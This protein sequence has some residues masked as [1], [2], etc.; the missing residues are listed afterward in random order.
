M[1]SPRG[2]L[3]GLFVLALLAGSAHAQ[4][5]PTFLQ[6]LQA[7]LAS[8]PVIQGR[9][10]AE[11]AARSDL[12]G[13]NWQ[14]YP[15]PS[16]EVASQTSGGNT[17]LLRVEQPLWTGGRITAL[18][19]GAGRRLDA[20]GAAVDEISLDIALRVS[21]AYAEGLRQQGRL[22]HAVASVH[23][24]EKLLG[25]IRRR[26][27]QEVSPLVDQRLAEARLY[28]ASNDVSLATQA[29]DAAYAQLSQLMGQPL[30]GVLEEGVGDGPGPASVGVALDR[31]LAFSPLL[32]RLGYEAD[33]ADAEIDLRRAAYVPQ[34]AVRLE[35]NVGSSFQNSQP[36]FNDSRVMLVLQAQ[37][38][39][40]LS[41][42]SG[43]EA[44]RARREA[45][46]SA[47]HAGDRDSRER[48]TIDWNEWAAARLRLENARL[49]VAT[50]DEVLDSYTRQYVIGRKTWIDVLN[51]VRE[52]AL[53][54]FALEDTRAQAIA[55]SLRLRANS[56]TLVSKQGPA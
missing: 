15:T 14:R 47:R 40:G 35:R 34:L 50:S 53:S 54:Q 52:T 56:G 17:G 30:G 37:P 43:V 48:T 22:R 38:G 19:D 27:S 36:F 5:V 23:Q 20:A 55:A 25:M 9:R 51:A 41:S 12:E 44:A 3:R 46:Q 1:G 31:A 18:I 11:G 6:V 7:A 10:A 24:H 42:L 29:R 21:A 2:L 32:R 39:A 4:P 45:A 8:H 13:A 26:V 33:A 28:Q 16:F 49:A